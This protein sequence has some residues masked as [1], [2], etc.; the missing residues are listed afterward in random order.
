[1]LVFLSHITS[2]LHPMF[3]LQAESRTNHFEGKKNDEDIWS[4]I[5]L[6]TQLVKFLLDGNPDSSVSEVICY[7]VGKIIKSIFTPNK[8]NL[9]STSKQVMVILVEG[10]QAVTRLRRIKNKTP[11]FLHKCNLSHVGRFMNFHPTW[12]LLTTINSP[13][14]NHL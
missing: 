8:R 6:F 12:R 9:C 10:V 7:M 11:Q 14:I 3:L 4:L 1:M 5:M 2:Y 13:C